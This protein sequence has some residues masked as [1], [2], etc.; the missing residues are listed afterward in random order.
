M[1]DRSLDAQLTGFSGTSP[2]PLRQVEEAGFWL[3]TYRQG[4]KA[5]PLR[6][7]QTVDRLDELVQPHRLTLTR[8]YLRARGRQQTY[9]ERRI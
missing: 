5:D 9:R 7:Y 4:V 8:E 1:N 2:D 6:A 3:E